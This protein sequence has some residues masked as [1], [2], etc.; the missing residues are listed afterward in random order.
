MT[1]TSLTSSKQQ[2]KNLLRL[3]GI[4][5]LLRSTRIPSKASMETSLTLERL[6][7]EELLKLLL[8]CRTLL[9]KELSGLTWTLPV[10]LLTLEES[11]LV[12][13][14]QVLVQVFSCITS[15]I[16]NDAKEFHLQRP[17]EFWPERP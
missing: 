15:R 13:I 14:K 8:S 4:F 7:L 3:F 16:K 9:R 5:Q 6:D 10:L 12:S 11:L 1:K 2:V 17:Y